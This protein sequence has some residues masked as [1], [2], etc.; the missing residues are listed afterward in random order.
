MTLADKAALKNVL[1]SSGVFLGDET[2]TRLAELWNFIFEHN[3]KLNLISRKTDRAEGIITHVADALTLLKHPLPERLRFLDFGTGAGFPGLPLKIARPGWDATLLESTRKKANFLELAVK[4]F[5][6]EQTRVVNANAGPGC[7][8]LPDLWNGFD[9]VTARAVD[10]IKYL[11]N[12]TGPMLKKEGLLA[13]YKGPNHGA[14]LNVAKSEL[15]K[16]SLE[17]MDVIEFKIPIID[18]R[19]SLLIFKKTV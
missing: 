6:L 4:T 2:A 12:R 8:N 15:K 3:A 13:A 14:E 10:K 19:R 5:G 9:L 1:E 16:N 7:G 11:A 18:S 17:L